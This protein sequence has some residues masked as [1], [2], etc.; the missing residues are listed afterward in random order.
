MEVMNFQMAI[1][2]L[3]MKLRNGSHVDGV[4]LKIILNEDIFP[5]RFWFKLHYHGR[6]QL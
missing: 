1:T 4:A 5:R 3:S 6:S 2:K